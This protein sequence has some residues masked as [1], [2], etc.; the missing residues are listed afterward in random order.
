MAAELPIF[1]LLTKPTVLPR[2]A[3]IQDFTATCEAEQYRENDR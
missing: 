1:S 2:M 3:K